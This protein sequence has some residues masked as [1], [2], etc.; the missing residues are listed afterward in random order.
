MEAQEVLAAQGGQRDGLVPDAHGLQADYLA[1]VFRRQVDPA[2]EAD[3]VYRLLVGEGVR[4]DGKGQAL[5]ADGGR[6]GYATLKDYLDV[7]V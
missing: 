2:I 1:D 7:L 3:E 4:Q 6:G 5:F